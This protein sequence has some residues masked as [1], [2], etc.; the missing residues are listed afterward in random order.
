[1]Q[2]FQQENQKYI[3][4]GADRVAHIDGQLKRI[5]CELSFTR[6]QRSINA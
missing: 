6:F 3:V 1:M 2:K 4:S 5:Y